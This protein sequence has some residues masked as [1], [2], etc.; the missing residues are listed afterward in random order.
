MTRVIHTGDTHIGYRQYH[1]PDRRRDFLAAFEQVVADAIDEGVDA[2]VHAGDL[3][4][5][6][7]PELPDLLGTLSA[8][9]ELDD[10]DIPFLAIVGNHESTRVGQWLDLYES[11]GLATRL[12]AEPVTVGDTA[13]Y[14]LDHVPE[15]RRDRLDYE[16]APHDTNHAT[17]VGHGL[18]EPFT[19]GN[20]DTETVLEE[21]TVDFDA[22]LLGDNHTPDTAEVLDTWVTYCG[23]TER[24]SA[25]ER[26]GRGYNIV[27][28]ADGEV[29]IR[30]RALETRSFVFVEAE[31]GPAEG[32]S[33]VRDRIREHD[34][35]DAVVVVE[36]TGD[37]EPIAPAAVE[38]F[39]AERGALIAR[40][41]DRREVDT[42]AEVSVNFADPDAA[43]RERVGEL[44]LS[45]VAHDIDDVV[46]GEA[47][48]TNVRRDVKRRVEERFEGEEF[49]VAVERAERPEV[50]EETEEVEGAVEVDGPDEGSDEPVADEPGSTDPLDGG[51]E[52]ASEAADGPADTTE[53][54][55]APET[56]SDAAEEGADPSGRHEPNRAADGQVTMEDFE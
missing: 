18:F 34:V 44:G 16:F 56:E 37:G 8:L 31:L 9:R 19:H 1:S 15:S 40:V 43:V 53:T 6:R 29:D 38:E 47:A 4:H 7:R 41:T 26:D 12:G 30:R 5:D 45:T 21:A 14:G 28:F 25:S 24:A 3:F 50:D 39:A 52:P 55:P 20:W 13:F 42:E 32:V 48:D 35:S 51:D 10:A 11:L 54:E 2:V 22:I 17:L 46:R 49:R 27:Q 23:S 33:R 36:V